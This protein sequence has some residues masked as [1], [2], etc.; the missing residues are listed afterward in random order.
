M[1]LHL[2]ALFDQDPCTMQ[3]LDANPIILYPF[4]HLYH[5]ILPVLEPF[6]LN[7]FNFLFFL[8]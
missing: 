1:S 7:P 4:I 2:G 3:T 5:L 8:L 6:N